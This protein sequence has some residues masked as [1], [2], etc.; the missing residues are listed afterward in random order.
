MVLEDNANVLELA[1]K[2]NVKYLLID[3]KYEIEIDL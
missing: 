3:D 1:K 2:Y